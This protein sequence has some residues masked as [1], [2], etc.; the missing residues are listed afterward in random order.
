M[1]AIRG[2]DQALW[3]IN[4]KIYNV[5]VYMLLGGAV[6]TKIRTYTHA[7]SAEIAAKAVE[8]GFA[9]I[10]TGGFVRPGP[11]DPS[12]EIPSLVRRLGELRKAIGDDHLICIDNHG[13]SVPSVAIKKMKAAREG[14][15]RR[16]PR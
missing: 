14:F 8:M 16:E 15:R 2:I 9:G 5:P 1:S 10:K 4:G 13:Q 11:Y 7:F 3:Y 6:R 12:A